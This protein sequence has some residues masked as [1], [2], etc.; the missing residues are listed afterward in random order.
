MRC[1]FVIHLTV[2]VFQ[3]PRHI[4]FEPGKIDLRRI[5]TSNQH[6][7]GAGPGI[8]RKTLGRRGAQPPFDPVADM[9][10]AEFFSGGK[11]EITAVF[12]NISGRRR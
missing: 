8:G 10:F 1:S 2:D 3:R 12:R 4:A 9:G 7:I 11:A 6:I 5:I